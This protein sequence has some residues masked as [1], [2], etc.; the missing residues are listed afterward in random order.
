[1][2]GI[3][4]EDLLALYR[5]AALVAVPSL[6]EGFG[7]PLLEGLA[8]G[9]PVLASDI[10]P[11]RAGG[12]SAARYVEGCEE[13][14]AAELQTAL[15]DSAWRTA[16]VQTGPVQAEKFPWR[17]TAEATLAVYREAAA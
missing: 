4:D 14:W 6:I 3:S 17:T 16:S 15:G 9:A 7:F 2:V 13:A 8:A 11:L 1:L 5:G 12:G 10:Q